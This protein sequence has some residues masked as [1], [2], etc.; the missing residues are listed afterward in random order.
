MLVLFLVCI[1][2]DC[3]HLENKKYEWV[4]IDHLGLGWDN[5]ALNYWVVIKEQTRI[6]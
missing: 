5:A 4:Y 6:N 2:I 3:S 1:A